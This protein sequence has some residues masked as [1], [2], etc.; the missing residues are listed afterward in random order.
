MS[1]M[2][3]G[4]MALAV[5]S[6]LVAGALA[7]PSMASAKKITCTVPNNVLKGTALSGKVSCTGVTKG[8]LKGT[9]SGVAVPPDLKISFKFKG[10]NVK[11]HITNGHIVGS[12]VVASG[13][14]LTGTGKYKSAKAKCA[15]T[16]SLTTNKYVF[17]CK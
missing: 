13:A 14:K 10:G 16:G 6:A 12:N 8:T 3:R 11:V 5:S 7:G 4:V 2:N 15:V 9:Q 17:K 1:R